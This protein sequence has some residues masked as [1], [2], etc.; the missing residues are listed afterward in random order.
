MKSLQEIH[1]RGKQL[2]I[3]FLRGKQENKIKR[4]ETEGE[5]AGITFL[6]FLLYA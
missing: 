2:I 3:F 5:H 1:K 4:N 6:L